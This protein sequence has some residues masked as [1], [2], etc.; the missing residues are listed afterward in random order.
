MDMRISRRRF[1]QLA[2]ANATLALMWRSPE[3]AMAD[4]IANTGTSNH[5]DLHGE[6][7][8]VVLTVNKKEHRLKVD[9]RTTLLDLLRERLALTGSKKGCDQGQCGACTVLINGR[10]AYSCLTFAVM[11]DGDQ[12]MTIEGLAGDDLHALQSAFI[13]HDGFQCGY[14]TPGQIMSAAGL[15]TEKC[16]KSDSDVR[17]CMSGNLCRCGAYDNIIAAIQSVRTGVN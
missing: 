12:V 2:I 10:R 4:S 14:C 11:H 13:E 9:S 15:L 5:T 7:A 6:I 16:G 3:K 1:H 8:D 17:E